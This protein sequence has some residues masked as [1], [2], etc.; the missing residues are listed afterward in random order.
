MTVYDSE[1]EKINILEKHLVAIP[2]SVD[3]REALGIV[4]D[5]NTAYGLVHRATTLVGKGRRVFIHGLSGA[6]GYATMTL[7]LLQGAEVYGTASER[8]HDALRRLGATPFTYADKEWMRAMQGLGGAHVVYDPLGFESWDESWEILARDEPSRLVGFG[9]NMN[10]VRA[11]DAKPRAQLPGQLRLLAKN[12]CVWTKRSTDFYWIDRDRDTF[13]TDFEAVMK[14]L[15]EGRIEV[16]IKKIWDLEDI[17]E[18]HEKWNQVQGM[19]SCLIRVD[20]AA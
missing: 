4:L 9:G 8:N 1:A 15:V 3:T 10:V 11:G 19:G 16:P 7:C 14:L 12:G 2:E 20:P 5:W 17:R 13:K 18:P 6:V